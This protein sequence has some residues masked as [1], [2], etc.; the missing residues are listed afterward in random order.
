[1]KLYTSSL[2]L[3]LNPGFW[4]MQAILL[5]GLCAH[6]QWFFECESFL[7]SCSSLYKKFHSFIFINIHFE[8]IISSSLYNFIFCIIFFFF[9]KWP[10]PSLLDQAQRY[11]SFAQVMSSN[12]IRVWYFFLF[13]SFYSLIST[14]GVCWIRFI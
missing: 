11:K 12:I 5:V 9:I 10:A 4:V 1:M 13:F 14:L 2:S 7:W 3:K 8:F 6:L